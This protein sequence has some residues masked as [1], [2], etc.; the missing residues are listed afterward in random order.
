MADTPHRTW[1]TGAIRSSDEGRLRPSLLPWEVF[2]RLAR[3]YLAGAK[4]HGD[5]NWK[6]G[7]PS[8]SYH[9]SFCRHF[10]LYMAGDTSEDH[11]SAMIFNLCGRMYNERFHANNP[12]IND[13]PPTYPES[14]YN[15]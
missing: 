7:I 2:P 14:N 9:E 5:H 12:L 8:S 10:L 3:H 15:V 13:M 11:L 1:N 4:D 6:K